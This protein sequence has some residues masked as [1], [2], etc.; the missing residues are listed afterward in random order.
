MSENVALSDDIYFAVRRIH[1]CKGGMLAQKWFLASINGKVSKMSN[2]PSK[3]HTATVQLTYSEAARKN[4]WSKYSF[5]FTFDGKTW[6]TWYD[7]ENEAICFD[8]GDAAEEL[9][10]L[11]QKIDDALAD[12]EAKLEVDVLDARKFA[13]KHLQAMIK[14]E[15]ELQRSPMSERRYEVVESKPLDMEKLSFEQQCI[16]EVMREEIEKQKTTFDENGV[17]DVTYTITKEM[18]EAKM[19]E[20]SETNK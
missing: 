9:H 16:A 14:V 19:R 17:G 18:V 6:R 10:Q 5:D 1:L 15:K 3:F 20:K 11:V 13:F 12:C 8:C 4:A 7:P 2:T